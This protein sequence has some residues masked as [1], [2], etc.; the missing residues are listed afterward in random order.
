MSEE[1]DFREE[2]GREGQELGSAAAQSSGWVYGGLGGDTLDDVM[3]DRL[4]E[5]DVQPRDKLDPAHPG[6]ILEVKAAGANINIEETSSEADGKSNVIYGFVIRQISGN[7]TTL[8]V[9][10]RSLE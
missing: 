3:E 4:H 5:G 8:G 10:K 2:N 9:Q 1:V 7:S 6:E